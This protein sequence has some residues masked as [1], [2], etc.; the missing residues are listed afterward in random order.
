MPDQKYNPKI[1]KCIKCGVLYSSDLKE[2]PLCKDYKDKAFF[3]RKKIRKTF[4]NNL[5]NKYGEINL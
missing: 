4:V 5:K 2:C 3:H 1:K